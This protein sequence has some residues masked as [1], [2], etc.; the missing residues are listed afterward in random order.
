MQ[1]VLLLF[2][3]LALDAMGIKAPVEQLCD[4]YKMELPQP[5]TYSDIH[6]DS[7]P[8]TLPMG[9]ITSFYKSLDKEFEKKYELLYK[10]R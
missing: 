7:V 10:E 2:R 3:L 4:E 9:R 8:Q 6:S 1:V 5:N